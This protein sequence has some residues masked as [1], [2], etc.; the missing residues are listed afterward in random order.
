MDRV[1]QWLNNL[2]PRYPDSTALMRRALAL[3]GVKAEVEGI[4][5]EPDKPAGPPPFT[6]GLIDSATFFIQEYPL[7]WLVKG[8]TVKD[9]PGVFGGPTKA[10]KTSMLIDKTISI[11]TATPFLGKFEVPEPRRVALISGE[12]GKRAI[13]STARQV[14]LARDLTARDLT[15]VHWGFTLPQISN[16]EHM[17]VMRKT[18]GDL[19]LQYA[20]LDPLYLA[21]LAGSAGIDPKNMFEMGPLLRDV[22]QLCIEAGC[23]PELAHHF[24]KKRDDPF[25]PPER[26]ELAYSGIDQFMR[27]WML[28]APREKFDAEIGLFKLHFHYGGSAGHCGEYAVDIEVG[29]LQ[30]DFDGRK[31]LVSIV[32]PSEFRAAKQEERQAEKVR[33]AAEKEREKESEKEQQ[34]RKAMGTALA[35]FQKVPDHRLSANGLQEATGWNVAKVKRTLFLLVENK[36]IR[37]VDFTV[38]T[39]NGAAKQVHGY[40]LVPEGGALQ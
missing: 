1:D 6:L 5:D 21:L 34:E 19:G 31:W 22:A 20:A 9:E 39:G 11:G 28:V 17:K 40:E 23:T 8:V 36:H 13:Q 33:K 14:C 35:F 16:A 18:I 24:V 7:V 4:E 10:L 27:Q 12:S 26:S 15:N 3:A 32:C 37:P 25:G 29:K 38:Q 30:P 2:E